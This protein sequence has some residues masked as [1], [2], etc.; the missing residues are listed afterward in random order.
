MTRPA[1]SN[2]ANQEHAIVGLKQE[3]KTVRGTVRELKVQ[4]E[5][6]R[7]VAHTLRDLAGLDEDKFRNLLRAE[8]LSC[9]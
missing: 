6:W 5:S 1:S 2:S 7:K 9:E 3:I 8:S 4:A